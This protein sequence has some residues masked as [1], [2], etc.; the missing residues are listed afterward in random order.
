MF[1][2]DDRNEAGRRGRSDPDPVP[3]PNGIPMAALVTAATRSGQV[4]ANL[5]AV[6]EVAAGNITRCDDCSNPATADLLCEGL[7]AMTLQVAEL[8]GLADLAAAF[9]IRE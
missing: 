8:R 1:G 5:L 2:Y 9:G 7:L 3:E 6:L 4:A